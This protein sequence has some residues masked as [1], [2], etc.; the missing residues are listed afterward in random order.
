MGDVSLMFCPCVSPRLKRSWRFCIEWAN[1]GASYL[2]RLSAK[3]TASSM[4]DRDR[5]LHD[6]RAWMKIN[7]A[8]LIKTK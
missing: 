1:V 7:D 8:Y 4:F 6:G 3:K 2:K 5:G